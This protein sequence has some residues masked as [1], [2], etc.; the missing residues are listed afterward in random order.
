MTGTRA[1]QSWHI[2]LPAVS[3]T[4]VL[5]MSLLTRA[6]TARPGIPTDSRPATTA[7]SGMGG[8]PGFG[9]RGSVDYLDNVKKQLKA[10]DEEW[11]VVRPLLQKVVAARQVAEANRTMQGFGGGFG[12][13]PG[14]GGG[15]FAGPNAGMGGPRGGRGG[16]GGP[17][18]GPAGGFGPGDSGG[19]G[20]RRGSGGREGP[21]G[22]PA[23]GFGGPGGF[24]PGG[25]TSGPAGGFG[26][27]GGMGGPTSMPAGG[28]GGPGGPG[29]F[30]GGPG[31][32]MMALN[33]PISQAM[34]DLRTALEDAKST[35]D[36]IKDKVAAVRAA[37][38]KAKADLVAAQKELIDVLT[39]EQENI[40]ISLGYLD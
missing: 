24:G 30:G 3:L 35:P 15:A 1:R 34:S 12:A 27:R 40:L 6:Q 16:P 9:G 29:G 13:G 25:P 31:Q 38:Q 10:T 19:R 18:T 8:P 5:A 7:Q 4:I 39:S 11:K 26:G 23:G 33:D 32:G 36:E 20:E 22:G 28:L 14:F 2:M 21:T 17:T 37:R